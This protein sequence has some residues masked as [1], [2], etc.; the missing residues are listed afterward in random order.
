MTKILVIDDDVEMVRL[1]K[2]T[3]NDSE[4]YFADSK[5]TFVDIRNRLHIDLLLIDPRINNSDQLVLMR[6]VREYSA[7]LPIIL[8][9]VSP[10]IALLI[11][12]INLNV[13]AFLEKPVSPD[14]LQSTVKHLVNQYQQR[15]TDALLAQQMREAIMAVQRTDPYI[16]RS[17]RIKTL[18]TGRLT[19]NWDL[20]EAKIKDQLLAISPT[21]FRILWYLV[22][23]KGNVISYQDLVLRTLGYAVSEREANEVIKG[24]ISRLRSKISAENCKNRI[25]TIR[26]EGYMW[27]GD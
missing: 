16:L 7:D 3:L 1:V 10:D 22:E 4:L 14:I 25:R 11:G 5:S 9:S 24:H 19:L 26:N 15:R 18:A 12:A 21:Q 27:V 13:Q 6:Q 2:A 23:A 20:Y 17:P 8:A